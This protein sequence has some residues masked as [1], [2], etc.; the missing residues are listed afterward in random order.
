MKHVC[1][2]VLLALASGFIS[3]AYA[4][5][6]PPAPSKIPNGAEA[7]KEELIVAMQTLKRYNTDVHNY[8]KC[9]EFEANQNRLT[10]EEQARRHNE[11]VDRLGEVAEKFNEQLR[12]FKGR[13]G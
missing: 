6:L 9:I 2:L 7:S 10:R 12:V 8:T 13:T 11:A 4:C 5:S 3:P 1:C